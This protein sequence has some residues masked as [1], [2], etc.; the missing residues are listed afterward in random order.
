M[1]I[2]STIS[3]SVELIPQANDLKVVRML[4]KSTFSVLL[5]YCP[6]L[7]KHYALKAYPYKDNQ[8]L[9]AYLNESR[10]V[11]LSH[12]N[13]ISFLDAQDQVPIQSN[14]SYSNVSCIIMEL[15]PYGDFTDLLVNGNFPH[16]DKLIR[17]YF[18]QLVEGL[19]YLHSNGIAHLDLKPEN[20]L[21]GEDFK[22][23]ITDFD[24]SRRL[25]DTLHVQRGTQNFRAPEIID[26]KCKDLKAA[27][28]YSLGVVLFVLKAQVLPYSESNGI[29][30]KLFDML[31]NEPERYVKT[32]PIFRTRP[33]FFSEEFNE[34]FL[35]MMRMNP[36]ERPTIQMIKQSRWYNGEIYSQKDLSIIMS[37]VA[38]KIS[39]TQQQ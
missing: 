38:Q 39:F 29:E 28:I 16:D 35:S 18:H 24:H 20:L 17:T 4:H 5:T 15:A 8:V 12:P 25:G 9:P 7:N 19:D 22:L 3:Q 11:T 36:E 27:D 33:Q 23:K 30:K 6:N 1:E 34:L 21:L 32:H 10:F 37:Q 14:G 2:E 31:L 13:V 26:R